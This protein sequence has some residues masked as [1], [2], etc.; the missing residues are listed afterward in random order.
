M[1][2]LYSHSYDDYCHRGHVDPAPLPMKRADYSIVRDISMQ[3]AFLSIH[4]FLQNNQEWIGLEQAHKCI[5]LLRQT[6]ETFALSTDP[7]WKPK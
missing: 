4:E 6:A 1:K 2:A 3:A 7:Q 5:D